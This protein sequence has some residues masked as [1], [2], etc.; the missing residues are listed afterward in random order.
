MRK[1]AAKINKNLN[2]SKNKIEEF[3]TKISVS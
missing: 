3:E 2:E 1:D